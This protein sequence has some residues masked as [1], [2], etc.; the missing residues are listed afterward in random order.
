MLLGLIP[1]VT[2]FVK[3]I[4]TTDPATYI[5]RLLGVVLSVD[6]SR[7]DPVPAKNRNSRGNLRSIFFQLL[8]NKVPSYSTM[9]GIEQ[10]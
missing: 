5:K 4:I 8:K 2:N 7:I 9:S 6:L 3:G 10:T 1:K